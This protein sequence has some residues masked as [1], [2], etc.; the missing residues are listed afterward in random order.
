MN[1]GIREICDVVFKAR[2]DTY[3]GKTL[4]KKGQPVLYI[5][6]AKTSSLEGAATTV[7]AQGGKGNPRLIAWEGERTLTFTVE[8]AVISP[9]SFA[10]L[11][12]A[13]LTNVSQAAQ[14]NKIRVHTTFDLPILEGGVVKIDYDDARDNHDIYISD[15]N[16][17][18]FGTILDNAG[19]GVV[20]TTC[21]NVAGVVPNCIPGDA[22]NGKIYTITRDNALELTFDQADKYVGKTMRVDCYCEKSTGATEITIDSENFAGNYYV[23]ASTL[24]REQHSSKDFPAEI[25]IPNAK[26][27]SN[28]TFTMSNTGDPSTFTFT[29]DAFPDYTSFDKTHKVFAAIQIVGDE[30]IHPDVPDDEQGETCPELDPVLESVTAGVKGWAQTTFPDDTVKFSSLGNNLRASVD[31]AN[32]DFYGNLNRIPNWTAFSSNEA[33]LTGHY[34][35]FQLKA[36]D[37]TK[38]VRTTLNGE[39]KTLVFGQ[40]GDGEGTINMIWAIDDEYPVITA[41]LVSADDSKTTEYSFDFSKCVFK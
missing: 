7:Y 33:D 5:T 41:K 13:G 1:L 3:V 11:S 2:T 4:F 27:Q 35:P 6:T 31:R 37:G 25:V 9:I 29:M 17:Q 15:N 36:A 10:M 34:Y 14:D 40:T 20:F 12:G 39:E 21:T 24:F 16:A 22:D 26:I 30:N 19:S 28:F 18:V 8:D 32:V 38:L 23:E